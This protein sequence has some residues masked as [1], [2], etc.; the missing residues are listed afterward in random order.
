[1]SHKIVFNV[2]EPFDMIKQIL[3]DEGTFTGLIHDDICVGDIWDNLED[4]L[5]VQV[6]VDGEFAGFLSLED[7]SVLKRRVCEVHAYILPRM[8]KY[9]LRILKDF[10]NYIFLESNFVSICTQTSTHIPNMDRVLKMVGFKY[11]DERKETHSFNGIK[12]D[13][14]FFFIDKE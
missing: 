13:S 3:E 5:L 1:M 14:H 6:S 11:F 10:R 12:Y 7:V 4:A 9:S 2:F 8:R